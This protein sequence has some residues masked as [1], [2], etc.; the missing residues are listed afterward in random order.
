MKYTVILFLFIISQSVVGQNTSEIHAILSGQLKK[1]AYYKYDSPDPD[2]VDI[3][4]SHFKR[5]LIKYLKEHTSSLYS[6]MDKVVNAGLKI[7]SSDDSLFRIYSW[8]TETGGTMRFYENIYQ[9]K[10]G[11]KVYVLQPVSDVEGEPNSWFSKIYTLP[12]VEGT[13]YIGVQYSDFSNRD[14][15]TGL[16]FFKI[17]FDSLR[18]NVKLVKTSKGME[19]DIGIGYDFFSVVDRTERP[20]ELIKYDPEAKTIK[21]PI[22]NKENGSVTDKFKEYKFTGKY[23]EEVK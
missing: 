15:Y 12:T 23:F 19:S 10:A 8:D 1:I 17:E 4:N 16:G 11:N 6:R 2:S 3:S 21:V 13:Y 22:V 5:V 9:Y 14:K 7:A 18:E 20:L